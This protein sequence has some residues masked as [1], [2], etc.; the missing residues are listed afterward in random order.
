MQE[1]IEKY[2]PEYKN[3]NIEKISERVYLLKNENNS[4]ILRQ[5]YPTWTEERCFQAYN[6]L[7]LVQIPEVLCASPDYK[8]LILRYIE[9]TPLNPFNIDS[10]KFNKMIDRLHSIKCHNQVSTNLVRF[11]K[12]IQLIKTRYDLPECF[13]KFEEDSLKILESL[14]PNTLCH[15]DIHHKNIIDTGEEYVLIDYDM[16]GWDS[17]ECDY[18]V[19]SLY[20]NLYG[21]PSIALINKVTYYLMSVSDKSQDSFMSNYWY[22]C[23][24]DPEEIYDIVQKRLEEN[25]ETKNDR[26][27]VNVYCA[28]A[29]FLEFYRIKELNDRIFSKKNKEKL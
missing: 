13:V 9:G 16:A 4:V 2:F 7:K 11:K 14:V 20:T 10:E 17:P 25:K 18:S 12:Q 3:F 5:A 22:D 28:K 26:L 19:L 1:I 21:D 27:K 8:Y 6:I 15:L 24:P 29:A 23:N